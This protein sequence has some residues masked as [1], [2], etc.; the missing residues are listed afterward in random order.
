MPTPSTFHPLASRFLGSPVGAP[1]SAV[2]MPAVAER[3]ARGGIANDTP[4]PGHLP[5][6]KASGSHAAA[7]TFSNHSSGVE[8]LRD[9]RPDQSAAGQHK[10]TGKLH[11][12]P[13]RISARPAVT[14]SNDTPRGNT[15]EK[16][17]GISGRLP[18]RTQARVS[19][20]QMRAAARMRPFGSPLSHLHSAS[21]T[22]RPCG[23]C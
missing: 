18:K 2:P 8:M 19:P 13:S 3:R 1:F 9:T 20:F 17:P 5:S 11:F 4:T 10:G 22:R 23:D 12:G 16:H 7:G 21:M 6:G 15:A 14:L